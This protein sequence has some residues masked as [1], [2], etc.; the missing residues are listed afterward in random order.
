[1]EK[2]AAGMNLVRTLPCNVGTMS[3]WS[4]QN[5]QESPTYR[6]KE[7][8]QIGSRGTC[9]QLKTRVDASFL[10]GADVRSEQAVDFRAAVCPVC[11]S[12]S[13]TKAAI[14][15]ADAVC[16]RLLWGADLHFKSTILCFVLLSA[17]GE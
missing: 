10:A 9:V 2:G 14:R 3:G 1:M 11:M 13:H 8:L 12:L 6:S 15:R 7:L 4:H 5:H 16:Q 17:P